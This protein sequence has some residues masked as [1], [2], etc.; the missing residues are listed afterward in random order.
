MLLTLQPFS[1][2]H[3]DFANQADQCQLVLTNHNITD[4]L[5]GLNETFACKR[6]YHFCLKN[7]YYFG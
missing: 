2:R 1:V 7:T 6:T 5:C 3:T 4:A